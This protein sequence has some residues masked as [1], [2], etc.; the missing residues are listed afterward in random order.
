MRNE[1]FSRRQSSL[2]RPNG[3]IIKLP[4]LGSDTLPSSSIF[5]GIHIL[6]DPALGNRVGVSL[7]LGT[8]G[9]KRYIAPALKFKDLP[10]IDVLL[11]SHAHMGPYGP[12]HVAPFSPRHL[13]RH[14]QS[15]GRR[16]SS[17]L[18]QEHYRVALE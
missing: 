4:W 6:T 18:T 14:C 7:G 5:Y 17:R 2:S 15:H 8:V 1:P 3:P 16:P 11:L 9:P 13:Y 12:A 10:P